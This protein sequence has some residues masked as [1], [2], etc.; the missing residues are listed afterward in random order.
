M[1]KTARVEA[2]DQ[3]QKI[4]E[5]LHRYSD[6]ISQCLVGSNISEDEEGHKGIAA[7]HSINALMPV[8][9]GVYQL[10]PHIRSFLSDRLAQY[11]AM[12]SLTRITEQI[13]GGRAKWREL[14]DMHRSGDIH[15]MGQIEES[16]SYTLNEIVYFMGQNLR[17]LNHQTATDYGNVATMKRK[18][19]QNRFY[20][21]SVKTLLAELDQLEEF[22][23]TVD[24]E[25]LANGVYGMRQ[26]VNGRVKARMGDWKVQLNDIQAII[27][28][29][30]F[31]KRKVDRELKILY[32]TVLWMVKN[33]TL[34]AIEVEPG[35]SPPAALLTPS[36]IR[37]RPRVDINARGMAQE[38]VLLAVCSKLPAPPIVEPEKKVREKQ[39]VESTRTEII[40]MPLA[41]EDLL[42]EDLITYLL[43]NDAKPIE[44]SQWQ[45]ERRIHA[46][47]SEEEWVLYATQQL[48][49]QGIKTQLQVLPT[50]SGINRVFDD[51]MAFTPA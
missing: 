26:M 25:A 19:R 38:K 31:I 47:L 34:T 22:V 42:V 18:L 50:H 51:V 40:A 13:Q 4:L 3:V 43:S 20:A 9:E 8:E 21:D 35:N 27:S 30:L 28:K 36:P 33:P 48:G 12:Q 49:L 39:R 24:R 29:R 37:V 44:I 16:L 41:E 46:G 10:N 7:L 45:R 23:N 1:S 17:L 6:V 2:R 5:T 32:D 11:S 15:D 14:V